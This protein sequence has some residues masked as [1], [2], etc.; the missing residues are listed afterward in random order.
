MLPPDAPPQDPL[1]MQLQLVFERFL[2]RRPIGIDVS[3][4][5]SG[6]RLFAGAEIDRR[7]RA[8]H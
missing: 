7:N 2:N 1:E 8:D 5:E 4:F 6:R 3:F